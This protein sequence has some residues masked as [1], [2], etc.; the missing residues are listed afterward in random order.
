MLTS[1]QDAYGHLMYDYF[2][3][4]S[5]Q[6]I[7][8]RDD[9]FI[10]ISTGPAAY[11][12]GYE[13]W[14]GYERR[15]ID[16]FVRG[17]VLDIGCGAGRHS[18][19]LRQKGFDVTGIDVS[20]LAL[21]VCRARGLKKTRL[22]S[23]TQISPLLGCFDTIL[24]MGNNFSLL[25]KFD[26]AERLLKRFHRIT[27]PQGRIIALTRDP[28]ATNLREHLDYHRLNREK[29]RMAGEAKIRVRYKKYATPWLH[30]LMVSKKEMKKLLGVTGWKMI[31]SLDGP[32]G[33]FIAVIDKK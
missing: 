1:R 29:G 33:I 18:L 19:H 14:P 6:E 26:R 17:K 24:L 16:G 30:F 5:G 3:Y 10:S 9:G 22:L 32:E 25:G 21:R 23:I 15:A 2:R 7:I 20:P 27:S 13:N 8:E 4:G 12:Q 31:K 11:F 28:Y